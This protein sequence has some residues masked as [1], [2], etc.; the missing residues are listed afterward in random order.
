MIAYLSPAGLTASLSED[1]LKAPM[2]EF[3]FDKV[4]ILCDKKLVSKIGSKCSKYEAY[5]I[6][7]NNPFTGSSDIESILRRFV[8]ILLKK[9]TSDCTFIINY[10]MGT[11]KMFLIMRMLGDI[12]K[13]NYPVKT[14]FGVYYSK[15]KDVIFTEVEPIDL[16]TIYF[17]EYLKYEGDLNDNHMD[18]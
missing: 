13:N 12:L 5:L 18:Q 8:S 9:V 14:V 2:D 3:E 7:I 17:Q 6:G 1:F 4:F 11:G 16:E 15:T 10:S